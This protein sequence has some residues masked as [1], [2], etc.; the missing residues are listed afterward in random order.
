MRHEPDAVEELRRLLGRQGFDLPDA[1]LDEIV[2]ETQRSDRAGDIVRMPAMAT[3][4]S[5][6]LFR[7]LS[8]PNRTRAHGELTNDAR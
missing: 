4:E 2:P 1:E 7:P 6:A 5:A 8:R 3:D